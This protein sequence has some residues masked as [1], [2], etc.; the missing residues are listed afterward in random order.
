MYPVSNDLTFLVPLSQI[1]KR[2][3]PHL[4]DLSQIRH[5]VIDEAD[6]MIKQGSFPELSRI[7]DAVSLANP[8]E[9]IVEA[10]KKYRSQESSDDSDDDRLQNLPGIRG[11]A[12]VEMLSNDILQRLHRQQDAG[13]TL[14]DFPASTVVDLAFADNHLD[15]GKIDCN[16]LPTVRRTFVYSATLTLPATS[17][18]LTKVRHVGV[19]GA[20]AEIME[21]ARAKGK[22]K[23]VDLSN[24]TS[25]AP[26]CK[27][28]SSVGKLGGVAKT[29][30]LPPGLA[31]HHIKCAQVH[32][33]SHLYAFLMSLDD[34]SKGPCLV[35]CNSIA[36]VRRVG[37]TLQ[38]LGVETRIL[39]AQMQQVCYH[40]RLVLMT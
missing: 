24:E 37:A 19:E 32:K 11:E 17:S 6:R 13:D 23:I 7:L 8:M 2:V 33:D 4:K 10:A 15:E 30:Q 27:D 5:L 1:A 9:Y 18:I 31:F 20:I 22:I 16:D 36:A 35:F 39:H 40:H 34:A 12:K 28:N 3:H 25:K 14:Y 38:A 21:R 26:K 29:I